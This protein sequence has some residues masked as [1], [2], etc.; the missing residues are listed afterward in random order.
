MNRRPG[1][2]SRSREI[3]GRLATELARVMDMPE[4][5]EKLATTGV[6]VA[7]LMGDEFGALVRSD[8]AR[9]GKLVRE[10]GLKE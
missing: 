8:S 6:D 10:L 1:F 4:T 3:T 9:Y 2:R 7:V 5:R